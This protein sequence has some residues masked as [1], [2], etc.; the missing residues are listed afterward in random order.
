MRTDDE[1]RKLVDG[2]KVVKHPGMAEVPSAELG[3]AVID[4][5]EAS[6]EEDQIPTISPI[7]EENDEPAGPEKEKARTSARRAAFK[8]APQFTA[9][10][11]VRRQWPKITDAEAI[12]NEAYAWY[13][14]RKP[15][16]TITINSI[17]K[18]I[19][20]MEM[21]VPGQPACIIKRSDA[22][23]ISLGDFKLRLNGTVVCLG[24]DDDGAPRWADAENVWRESAD[25]HL[26]HSIA[27]TAKPVFPNA[28]N[29]FRGFGVTPKKGETKLIHAFICAG[30]A[31]DYTALVKLIAWQM[32]NIGTASR[33]VVILFSVE[34]Q[35]GKG[36]LIE[37]LLLPIF[38]DT[39]H[40]TTR[41]N[42]IVGDFNSVLRARILIA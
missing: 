36:T 34:Q 20:S 30:N 17:T 19:S 23:P 42:S 3:D 13:D 29:L 11:R 31:E 26:Y 14:K 8:G 38:G 15:G 24:I 1:L 41:L 9:L 4:K 2:A 33:I 40:V 28:M 35:V 22:M 6:R 32:Q 7:T 27:F 5:A 37:Y 39:G 12:V 21:L 10:R 16:K 18:M 25:K